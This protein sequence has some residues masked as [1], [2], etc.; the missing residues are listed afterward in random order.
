MVAVG[1]VLVIGR[2]RSLKPR[3]TGVSFD[4]GWVY[5]SVPTAELYVALSS[6]WRAFFD[7]LSSQSRLRAANGGRGM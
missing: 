6:C 2:G 3:R 1:M 7:D 4:Q 5:T